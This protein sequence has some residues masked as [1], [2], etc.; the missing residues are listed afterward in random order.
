MGVTNLQSGMAVF[1]LAG[2]SLGSHVQASAQALVPMPASLSFEQAATTP[3]VF[4]TVDTAFNAAAACKPGDKVLVHAAAGG[5]GLAALQQAA[6]LGCLVCATAGSPAKRML[7][8]SIGIQHAVNSRDTSC[9]IELAHLGGIDVVLNSLT[10]PGMVAGSVAGIRAGGRLVEISKRDIWSP[11]RLAQDRPDVH[12]SLLAVDFLPPSSLQSGLLKLSTFLAAGCLRPLPH[13]VHDSGN[14]H[15]ALRQMSQARHVGKIVVRNGHQ[16]SGLSTNKGLVMITGGLGSLGTAVAAWLS[17][18]QVQHLQLTGRTGK[19]SAGLSHA[20]ADSRRPLSQAQV[21][22]H[23]ADTSSVEE[24]TVLGNAPGQL[25]QLQGIMHASGVLADATF[26]NQTLASLRQAFA[27]KTISASNLHSST[28]QTP[29]AFQVLFSSVTALLG[30]MGQA[31]YAAAN[32]ALDS[33]A[34]TWQ[35]EGRAAVSSIQWGGWAGGGMASADASTAARLARTGMALIEP[36]QGLAALAGVLQNTSAAFATTPAQL[37]VVPFVWDNFLTSSGQAQTAGIFDEFT[38]QLKPHSDAQQQ[39]QAIAAASNDSALSGQAPGLTGQQRL[40][41]LTA[42]VAAAVAS[43]LGS[44]VPPAEPLMAAGLDSLGAV[45]LKNA[46]ETHLG[47]ELPSTL[48]F[49]YPSVNAIADYVNSI[50]P[51]A[52][53]PEAPAPVQ[54]LT[55]PISVTSIEG[56]HKASHNLAV[57]T[58]VASRSARDVIACIQSVDVITPVPLTHWDVEQQTGAGSGRAGHDLAAR[59]GGFLEGLDMFDGS[60]FGLS[61]NEAELM[62]PQQRMLLETSYQ[63][64]CRRSGANQTKMPNDVLRCESCVFNR[65]AA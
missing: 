60:L 27:P 65:L 37:T 9:A 14:V 4:L 34:A 15:S 50:M 11:A 54:Q 29:L 5:V 42:E 21:V 28:Q 36:K 53:E 46:L 8:R 41:Y 23:R 18:Q 52:A 56:S 30:G 12:Y 45:E 59:F 26:G 40:A 47:L 62:D 44:V 20:L 63:V 1:G 7:L 16:D 3:T 22:I 10:S 48:I 6:L 25:P 49:D 43:V 58:G 55:V 38:C 35:S 61:V 57:V 17:Q 51:M 24:A 19:L 39:S 33:L 13:A 31:N 32:A 2:G 64:N